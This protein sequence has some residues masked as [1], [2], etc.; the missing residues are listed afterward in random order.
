MTIIELI[1]AMV[2]NAVVAMAVGVLLIG[3]HRTWQKTYES[4]NKDIRQDALAAQVAFETIGRKANRLSYRIYEINGSSFIPVEPETKG[5]EVVSGDA[6]EFRYWDVAL[7]RADSHNLMDVNK[8]ATAYA[9]FYIEDNELKLDY[10]PYPPGG[11]AEGGGYRNVTG[12][13]TIVLADNVD[14][15]EVSSVGAFSHTMIG[16]AGQGSVRMNV[17]LRDPEDDESVKVM[18]ATLMRNIWPR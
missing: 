6:V 3:G 5:E 12:V 11:I 17:I 16:G 9:L 2:I 10:G 18:T 14:T 7:D 15:E 1:T 8:T 13:N 4:A